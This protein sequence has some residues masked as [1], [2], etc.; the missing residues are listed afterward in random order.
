[1]KEQIV[2]KQI[3]EYLKKMGFYARKINSANFTGTPDIIACV[4]GYF[5]AFEVKKPG[6]SATDLQLYNIREIN[7]SLGVA[8]V[9]TS[10][11]E[12]KNIIFN[13]I[14]INFERK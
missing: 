13:S 8:A 7:K 10:L 3:L 14:S 2:Q 1:M 11:N 12:V 9:V 4:H 6:A 5:F